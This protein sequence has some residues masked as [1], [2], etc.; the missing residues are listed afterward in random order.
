MPIAKL[1][2][3]NWVVLYGF[4]IY[5]LIDNSLQFNSKVFAMIYTLLGIKHLTTTA[6][7]PESSRQVEG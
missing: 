6:Y 4:A 1:S 3:N 2:F 5:L 7:R